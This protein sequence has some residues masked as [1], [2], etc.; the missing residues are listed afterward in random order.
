M[1][2]AICEACGKRILAFCAAIGGQFGEWSSAVE[3]GA[4]FYEQGTA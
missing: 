3:T 4:C 1:L 2:K